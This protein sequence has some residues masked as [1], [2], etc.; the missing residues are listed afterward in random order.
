MI[1]RAHR[2]RLARLFTL[3]LLAFAVSPVTAPFTTCD[4]ADFT[5][6]HPADTGHHPG[7]QMAEARVRTAPHLVTIAFELAPGPPLHADE[8]RRSIVNAGVAEHVRQDLR[9]VLRL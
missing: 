7:R 4:L 2:T 8:G 1:R 9:T 3:C 6:S 5:Q